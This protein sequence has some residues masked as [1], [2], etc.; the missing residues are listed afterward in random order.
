MR[1]KYKTQISISKI[2][3]WNLKPKLQ[4]YNTA[5]HQ[6][7][8]HRRWLR[9]RG[10]NSGSASGGQPTFRW[11]HCLQ[12]SQ[13]SGCLMQDLWRLPQSLFPLWTSCLQ[14]GVGYWKREL[15]DFSICC[16]L[17]SC[18][19]QWHGWQTLGVLGT[20]EKQSKGNSQCSQCDR[21][22]QRV[23]S[24]NG[25]LCLNTN[26]WTWWQQLVW[27]CGDAR[28]LEMGCRS[29]PGSWRSG[30]DRQQCPRILS[31]VSNNSIPII[32]LWRKICHIKISTHDVDKF[33]MWQT[34]HMKNVKKIIR[35]IQMGLRE[36]HSQ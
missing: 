24:C 7:S 14:W 18:W 31:D 16:C 1:I 32:C 30:A 3:N 6:F 20:V 17:C 36:I 9:Q 11:R 23:S 27:S 5:V 26:D 13:E 12:R 4:N 19:W 25:L 28:W 8:I 35:N 33:S 34:V 22:H 29:S 10:G 21:H 2:W 15:Q